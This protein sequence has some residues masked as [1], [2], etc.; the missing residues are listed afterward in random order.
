MLACARV[1]G[2]QVRC[3]DL[4]SARGGRRD[5]PSPTLS[6]AIG[7]AVAKAELIIR[8]IDYLYQPAG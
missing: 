4:G 5:R 6:A 1:R 2:T 3:D 7:D 8:K